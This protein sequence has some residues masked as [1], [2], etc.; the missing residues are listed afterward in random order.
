[1]VAKRQTLREQRD[2]SNS[3]RREEMKLA[4]AEGRLIVRQMTSTE[5]AQAQL[6]RARGDGARAARTQ[7]RA[8]RNSARA[9]RDR[10]R[11]ARAIRLSA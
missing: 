6:D 11:A 1:M 9:G 7:A 4:I 10:A 2:A 8:A 5:H 3:R